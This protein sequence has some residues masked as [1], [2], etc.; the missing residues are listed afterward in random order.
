MTTLNKK[1]ELAYNLMRNGKN[2]FITGGGGVGKSW[3]I[4]YFLKNTYKKVGITSTTGVSAVIIGGTTLHSYLGIGL[5]TQSINQL[6]SN[7][8]KRAFYRE[9]WRTIDI[10]VIDEVSM[11]SP[12]LFDKLNEIAQIIRYNVVPF[13]GIQLIL[14]GDF[15][16]LP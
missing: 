4:N 12:E 14:S 1:Q 13:G 8:R 9:R 2:V 7:I 10:L 5:G 11:L 16:Q 6:V 15:C 3:L